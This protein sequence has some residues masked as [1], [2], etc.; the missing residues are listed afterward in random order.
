MTTVYISDTK[1]GLKM[2]VEEIFENLEKDGPV[3]KI[4]N[5]YT[6]FYF[7]YFLYLHSITPPQ[8]CY[9]KINLRNY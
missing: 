8:D 5:Y 7:H 1:K 6:F 9:T 4:H 3:L 2:A